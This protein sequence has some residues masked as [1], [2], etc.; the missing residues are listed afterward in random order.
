MSPLRDGVRRLV[1]ERFGGKVA[2]AAR[3]IGVTTAALRGFINGDYDVGLK[4]LRGCATLLPAEVA[5]EIGLQPRASA[6]ELPNLREAVDILDGRYSDESLA[7][8]RAA[9]AWFRRDAPLGDWIEIARTFER[10]HAAAPVGAASKG[11]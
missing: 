6:V 9:G 7:F 3:A 1:T 11:A 5:Q 10:A 4:M 2:P 8:L